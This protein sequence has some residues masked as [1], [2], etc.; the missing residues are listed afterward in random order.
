MK[1]TINKNSTEDIK[2]GDF[3]IVHDYEESPQIRQIIKYK[4]DF[5]GLDVLYGEEGFVEHS[6]EDLIAEYKKSYDVVIPVKNSDIEIVV[7]GR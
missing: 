3:L 6:L 5:I 2:V 4:G 1:L 7:G